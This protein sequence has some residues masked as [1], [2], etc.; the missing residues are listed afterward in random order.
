MA[1]QCEQNSRN[2]RCNQIVCPNGC[3]VWATACSLFSHLCFSSSTHMWMLHVHI[4]DSLHLAVQQRQKQQQQ[5]TLQPT[6]VGARNSTSHPNSHGQTHYREKGRRPHV[7]KMTVCKQWVVQ[8]MSALPRRSTPPTPSSTVQAQQKTWAKDGP[9]Q[10][11]QL[12]PG[13]D[14][15]PTRHTAPNKWSLRCF[16]SS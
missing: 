13:A 1:R 2:R 7:M 16:D 6:L 4:F 12:L 15:I 14:H 10:S 11:K 3:A 5:T 9:A 8:R